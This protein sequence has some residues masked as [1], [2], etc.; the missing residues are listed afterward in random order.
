VA[1]TFDAEHPDRAPGAAVPERIL[2][3]LARESARA[4]F[5][6]QGRWASAYPDIA[7]MIAGAGHLV[8]NHS[9]SHAPMDDL[10]DAGLVDDITEAETAI[11]MAAGVD[12]RPWFRCPFGAG[13]DDIRVRRALDAAGYRHI[14]WDVDVDDWE[15]DRTGHA[16]EADVLTGVLDHGGDTVVLLHTW[17]KATGDA[18]TGIIIR[19]RDAGAAFVGLDELEQMPADPGAPARRTA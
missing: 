16:V 7:R 13:A 11:R 15:I 2:D 18:L 12:P 19:L 3:I 14:G 8:G 1:L 9:H 17:P 5:F 4:T 10:T 6:L